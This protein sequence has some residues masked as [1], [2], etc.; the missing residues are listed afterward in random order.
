[1]NGM[2]VMEHDLHV[3]NPS[4]FVF[5]C[6]ACTAHPPH[7]TIHTLQSAMRTPTCLECRFC[8]NAFKSEH[9]REVWEGLGHGTQ[10]V[11]EG[12]IVKG[13]P[14]AVDLYDMTC[15]L[16]IQID[17]EQH[18]KPAVRA[19]DKQFNMAA[20]EQGF[21]VLRILHVD[22]PTLHYWIDQAHKHVLDR[23]CDVFILH[24]LGYGC[25]DLQVNPI[26]LPQLHAR[27]CLRHGP[28]PVLLG[29]AGGASDEH[30]SAST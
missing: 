9:E 30:H 5:D 13:W 1:M 27:Q 26:W 14:G 2:A 15:G 29:Q 17:G 18:L 16:I 8:N 4:L 19:R 7:A 6:T 28:H 3:S 11:V 20:A 23:A 22:I 24:S 10:Y 21:R 25:Q 12:R